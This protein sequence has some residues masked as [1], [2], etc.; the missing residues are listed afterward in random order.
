M[1]IVP[2]YQCYYNQFFP[3]DLLGKF[4]LII[5]PWH[6]CDTSLILGYEINKKKCYDKNFKLTIHFFPF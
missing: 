5:L 6:Q 4:A 1:A 2:I 3:F